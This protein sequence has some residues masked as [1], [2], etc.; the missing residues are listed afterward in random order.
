M[1]FGGII[2]T[3]LRLLPWAIFNGV[4]GASDILWFDLNGDFWID[5]IFGGF[6]TTFLL[7]GWRGRR[8]G[9]AARGIGAWLMTGVC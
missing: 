3:M 9:F 2:G 1:L 5:A 8:G 7:D 4:S 6:K